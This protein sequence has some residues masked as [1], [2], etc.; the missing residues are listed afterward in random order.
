MNLH[1]YR[2]KSLAEALRLVRQE[3]GPDASVLHTRE[4]GSTLS[5]WLG[6]RT[7]EV[8]ASA[9]LE[10]PSRLPEPAAAEDDGLP[11]ADLQDFRRKFRDDLLAAGSAESS[12][13][14]ELAQQSKRQRTNSTGL[15][16]R[17]KTAGISDATSQRWLA[18]L[19]AE[20]ACDPEAHADRASQRL[21]Q[22]IE[23]DLPVRGAIRLVSP[24]PT[25]V[26][27]VGPTG[28]GKTTTLAKLAAQFG[29]HEHRRVALVTVD[30]FR[31][32]AVE[33][34]RTYAE[35]MAL[36]IEVVATPDEMTAAIARLQDHDLIL[37]D[38]PGRSPRDSA[39]LLEL[40]A[41]LAAAQPH[42]TPLV[43]SCTS[44][45]ESLRQSA[46]A[47]AG[48]GATSLI[49]TKLDEASE[50]RQLPDWLA[51]CRL[52]LCYTTDGQNVPDDIRP[53]AAARLAQLLISDS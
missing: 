21:R 29:L 2:A 6:G 24:G 1:T 51:A 28:V 52:P 44:G 41:I 47:F 43:L 50:I 19:D 14:E 27:L 38:T 31:I 36:P 35:I 53:A 33:Q 13:V 3:L 16:Q 7:I 12:L 46:R 9:E 15:K 49:L 10:A 26:A 48:I 40:Q 45:G 18:R 4:V 39:G 37:V 34:L 23:A 5:R 25:V 22:I 11:T 32:G 8:T 30:T 42:E 20:L 17:L